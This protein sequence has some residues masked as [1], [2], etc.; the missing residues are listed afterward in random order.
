[1]PLSDSEIK[2]LEAGPKRR[3][4]GARNS[5]FLVVESVGR[6][7]VKSLLGITRFPPGGG[8]RRVEVRIGPYGRGPGKWT[9]KTARAELER[10]RTWS[11][12]K[13][14]D[15]LSGPR[16]D[17]PSKTLQDGIDGFLDIKWSLKEFTLTNYRRQLQNQVNDGTESRLPIGTTVLLFGAKAW[18]VHVQPRGMGLPPLRTPPAIKGRHERLSL[19]QLL[20]ATPQF[21]CLPISAFS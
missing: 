14:R 11:R 16:G 5:L 2:T 4:V 8:G 13:G 20:P 12:D 6:G 9:L 7:R 3:D 15:P 18:T 1:M 17:T 21:Y 19:L 10:I